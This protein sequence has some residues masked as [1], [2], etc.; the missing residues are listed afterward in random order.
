MIS[1]NVSS[2]LKHTLKLHLQHQYHHHTVITHLALICAAVEINETHSEIGSN[3]KV[4][5]Q[6]RKG[7]GSVAGIITLNHHHQVHQNHHH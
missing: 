3:I 2:V 6:S 1:I 5:S 7:E 4:I